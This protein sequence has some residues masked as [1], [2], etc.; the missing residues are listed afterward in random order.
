M[1]EHEHVLA[2]EESRNDEYD[3]LVQLIVAVQ[4]HPGDLIRTS[5][6]VTWQFRPAPYTV[7]FPEEDHPHA[8][9]PASAACGM[10]R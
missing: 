7:D 2:N 10:L 8:A 6:G 4:W 5:K 9:N 1:S 3:E